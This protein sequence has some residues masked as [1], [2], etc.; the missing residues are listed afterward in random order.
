MG[1]YSLKKRW[2][3]RD[4]RTPSSTKRRP[5]RKLKRDF[6]QG[7]I[8]IQNKGEWLQT[9]RFRLSIRRTF[10][11]VRVLRYCNRLPRDAVGALSLEVFKARFDGI[12]SLLVC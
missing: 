6:L 7:L 5:K 3:W 9:D 4:L 2:L 11:T 12:L 1:F 10:F 8:V